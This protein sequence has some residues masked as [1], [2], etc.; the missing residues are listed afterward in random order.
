[1]YSYK[2]R[3]GERMLSNLPADLI[4]DSTGSTSHCGLIIQLLLGKVDICDS[5]ERLLYHQNVNYTKLPWENVSRHSYQDF[6]D[7]LG[8]DCSNSVQMTKSQSFFRTDRRN[9]EIYKLFL[10][11]ITNFFVAKNK[12]AT[13][14][15]L[16]LYRALEFISYSF[17]MIYAANSRNYKGSYQHLKECLSGEKTGELRFF[18]RFLKV[19]FNNETTLNYWFEMNISSVELQQIQREFCSIFDQIN[20]FEYDFS[21]SVLK[22]RFR[23]MMTLFIEIRNR[24][25]HMLSGQR[26]ANFESIDY[27][28]NDLLNGINESL[29]NWL[30]VIF[31]E[32][33]K[34]G[35]SMHI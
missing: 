6:E 35:L 1:M 21:T 17:P 33:I 20:G 32:I 5:N 34:S 18:Q 27:D 3:I 2:S 16:H 24:Y 22:V 19:L 10:Y 31:F 15:Y 25:F 29:L 8:F 11:E 4:I 9:T 13:E 12:S 14:A 30:T 23:Y 26:T 7:A 28:I